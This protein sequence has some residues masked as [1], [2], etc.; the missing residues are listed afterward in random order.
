MSAGVLLVALSLFVFSV[1]EICKIKMQKD[2]ELDSQGNVVK[3]D[4]GG[5]FG[6]IEN[7]TPLG[8]GVGASFIAEFVYTAHVG[9]FESIGHSKDFSADLLMESAIFT[10][11]QIIGFVIFFYIVYGILSAVNSQ[12]DEQSRRD[13]AAWI[14]VVADLVLVFLAY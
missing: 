3:K 7:F 4:G 2:P 9:G 11:V 12:N 14:S 10:L 6:F 13:I 5:I 1:G 8:W